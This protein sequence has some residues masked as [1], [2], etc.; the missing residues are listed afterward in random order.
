MTTC[1]TKFPYLMNDV[2]LRISELH[3]ISVEFTLYVFA[4]YAIKFEAFFF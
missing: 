3:E 1:S 4:L 2:N